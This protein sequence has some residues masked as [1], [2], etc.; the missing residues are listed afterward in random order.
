MMWSELHPDPRKSYYLFLRR[1]YRFSAAVAHS[2]VKRIDCM[3]V[4]LQDNPVTESPATPATY[5]LLWLVTAARSY[6][7]SAL[8]ALLSRS[9]PLPP[10]A[11][12]WLTERFS[13]QR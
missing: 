10:A 9:T 4:A 2:K 8:R 3:V 5:R 1:G 7:R 13:H 6:T 12:H 11:E